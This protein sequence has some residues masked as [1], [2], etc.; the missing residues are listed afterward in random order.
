[1]KEID[2]NSWDRSEHF[3]F[4][5]RL[6]LP[7]YNVNFNLNITELKTNAKSKGISLNNAL[8][9]I[10]MKSINK[11]ENFK[12][13]L[14]NDK[15]YLYE[16]INLSFAHLKNGE[17][18]FRM[19]TLEFNDKL[20]DFNKQIIEAIENSSSYFN[21][22]ML[23]KGSNFAFISSLP[24]ISFTG[25]DHTLNLNKD[26]AI[27]RITWGKLFN[28]GDDTLLPYNIQ[29]NHIFIDGLHVGKFFETLQQ[30]VYDFLNTTF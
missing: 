6:D 4:F 1:M 3:N 30:E 28:Q 9:Y 21:L 7:F 13:R 12:Y 19:I 15:V 14:L 27:P 2:I 24:W 22:D 10:T 26:D 29:V 18:L 20:H 16:K 5:R 8:L 17:E 25:I 23:S 11:I